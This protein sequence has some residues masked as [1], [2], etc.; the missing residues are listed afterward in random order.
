MKVDGKNLLIIIS[1]EH[2]KDAIGFVAQFGLR[3]DF[4]LTP[5]GFSL[6]PLFGECQEQ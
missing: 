2:R 1:D 6:Q 4:P 5:D 3:L